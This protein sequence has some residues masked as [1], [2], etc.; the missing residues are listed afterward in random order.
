LIR[1]ELLDAHGAEIG[2]AT[3]EAVFYGKWTP[4][5]LAEAL[6]RSLVVQIRRSDRLPRWA[7]E[8]GDIAMVTVPSEAP[9]EPPRPELRPPE[10]PAPLVASSSSLDSRMVI[11]VLDVRDLS[12]ADT[13]LAID[14]GLMVSITSQLRVQLAQRGA[15]VVDKGTMDSTLKKLAQEMKTESYQACFDD[16]CQIELGKALAATHIL[17]S[18]IARFGSKC[19]LNVELFDLRDE[20]TVGGSSSRGDCEPES[21]L[22]MSE[23]AAVG[24]DEKKR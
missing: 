3:R 12:A 20:V 2:L 9:P 22:R 16:S 21:F 6:T 23:E 19:V 14:G 17:R 7:R 15:R 24:L 13:K 10:S 11:A 1:V 8:T 4:E 5:E 18:E